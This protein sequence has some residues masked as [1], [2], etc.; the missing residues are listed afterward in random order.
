MHVGAWAQRPLDYFPALYD[1]L[2]G[3]HYEAAWQIHGAM[4]RD[5][6][7]SPATVFARAIILYT[8]MIDFEDSTGEAEFFRCCDRV[9]EGCREQAVSAEENERVWLEFLHGS[10]LATRAFYIGRRGKV[11]PALK[12][13]VRARSLFSGVLK[14]DPSFYD[15]YMGRGVYRW[16]VA[17]RAGVL[18]G[19]PFV[20]SRSHALADLKLAIDSSRFSQHAAAS[21]LVW[22]LIEDGKYARAE[23][24]ITV[25]LNRFPS[26]RP[27]LWPLIALQYRTGRF[28]E[29]I[30]TSEGLVSQY[31]ASP[32]NNGYDVVGLYKRM[33]DAASKLDDHEAAL[34]YCQAGLAASVTSDVRQRRHRDLEILEKWLKR[35]Q[36]RL[37]RNEET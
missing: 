26:A 10:A 13:L 27:F 34:R 16:G 33:A 22:F 24:L 7:D 29:C 14:K 8:A 17:K 12:L 23:S 28:R 25:G 6:P 32:R 21:A 5:F 37:E 1:T 11:W 36:R 18:A 35:A 3:S 30:A 15:A 2:V 20:P 4:S 9:V 19:L 31:L